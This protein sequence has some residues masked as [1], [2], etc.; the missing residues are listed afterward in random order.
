MQLKIIKSIP[1]NVQYRGP[2][3]GNKFQMNQ[4]FLNGKSLHVICAH[5]NFS[6]KRL[7]MFSYS[8]PCSEMLQET[9][10]LDRIFHLNH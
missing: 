2:L 3:A 5:L 4:D 7:N 9:F 10:K 1:Y 6:F 8:L